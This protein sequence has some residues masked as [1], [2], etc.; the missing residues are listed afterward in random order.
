MRTRVK[1]CGITRLEDALTAALGGADAIGW[2]FYP[3]SPRA[4]T[5]EAAQELRSKLP[6]FV[7]TVGVF[8]NP[9]TDEVLS[10]IATTGITTV[11]LHGEES[12]EFCQEIRIRSA[13]RNGTP[14]KIIK[15]ARVKDADS[16]QALEPYQNA[17]DA[18]LLDGYSPNAHGGVGASF[19]W[20]LVNEAKKWNVPIILA[21][22]LNAENIQNAIQQTTPYGVDISSGVEVRKGVKCPEKIRAFLNAIGK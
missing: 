12:P 16:I 21:G 22:G 14:I 20:D 11:Q 15:A 9:T 10:T 6:P 1:I 5:P 3:P 2:M 8:V 18:W 4:I 7:D 19:N 17:C 13:D